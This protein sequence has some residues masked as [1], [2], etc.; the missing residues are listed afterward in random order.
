M[1]GLEGQSG[2]I[3]RDRFDVAIGG[4]ECEPRLL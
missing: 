3:G 2:A 1:I 4:G